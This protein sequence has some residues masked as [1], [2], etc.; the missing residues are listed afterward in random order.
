MKDVTEATDTGTQL[1]AKMRGT[2]PRLSRRAIVGFIVTTVLSASL[3][4][5]LFARLLSASQAV[6][7]NGTAPVVGHAAPDF[8][9]TVLNG[10]TA[11]QKIQ[12]A[13]LKGKPVVLNFWASW[14][15]PCSDEA[16]VL[17]AAS[18]KYA[19]QGVVFV[20]ITYED[21]QANS[22]QFVHQ[23]GVTYPT[24]PDTS[25]SGTGAIA[26]SYGVLAPPETFFID[27]TGTVVDMFGGALSPNMLDQRVAKILK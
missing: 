25:G 2:P 16:P 21:T 27:R 10:P 6:G 12:L 23:H 26:I 17:E 24:G 7:D 20:G 14:C 1:P 18:Q 9:I 19:A 3:L 4:L 8:T 5:L 13:D 11:G 15:V 22:L